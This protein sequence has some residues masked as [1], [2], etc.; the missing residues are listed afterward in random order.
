MTRAILF[1]ITDHIHGMVLVLIYH[2]RL[3]TSLKLP[4][5][6]FDDHGEWLRAS[7]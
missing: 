3:K 2:L 6:R 4:L 1:L 5:I 7:G